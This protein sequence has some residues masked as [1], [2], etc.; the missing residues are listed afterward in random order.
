MSEEFVA[1]PVDPRHQEMVEMNKATIC[2]FYGLDERL[3][4]VEA[5]MKVIR[6][7][8][9]YFK[10]TVRD[11]NGREAKVKIDKVHPDLTWTT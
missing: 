4:V 10:F 6:N 5:Q 2:K 3:E 8:G 9:T 7:S 1:I 11:C